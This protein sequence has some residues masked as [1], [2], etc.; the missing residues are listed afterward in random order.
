[1]KKKTK[2]EF[3]EE[4]KSSKDSDEYE[5]LSEYTTAIVKI[6]VRH[7]KC[8][9]IY[10]VTPNK[11]LAGRRCPICRYE[12]IKEKK[13][14]SFEQAQERILKL[15]N[16]KYELI[17]YTGL[18]NR[19][20]I[21]CMDCLAEKNIKIEN[22]HYICNC[23]KNH[24][25]NKIKTKKKIE[26]IKFCD[27][28]DYELM[29]EYLGA[30]TPC[31]ILHKSCNRSWKITPDN[32]KRGYGCPYCNCNKSKGEEKIDEVLTRHNIIFIRQYKFE[33]CKNIKCL[34][35][36]FYLPNLNICIE[37]NGQQHY[38][39][40]DFFGGKDAFLNT[41]KRDRIKEKYCQDNKI[42]LVTISYINFNDIE[43]IL[44]EVIDF[45]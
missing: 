2:E 1:M 43:N 33:D 22:R 20:K 27:E 7:I 12:T 9:H 11:W 38:E 37:Y 36:D 40:S 44:K 23:N 29:S 14:I 21:R 42:K 15:S 35:F 24:H 16:N 41:T 30:L 18:K 34:L 8:N 13:S 10:E 45:E 3:L 6:K 4:F 19:C 5:L 39:P 25:I 28:N 26:L 17:E 32:L 31:L